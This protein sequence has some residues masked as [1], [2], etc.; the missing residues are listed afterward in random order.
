MRIFLL[1][2]ENN[3][4]NG[5]LG[6]AALR[7]CAYGDDRY[8]EGG[9]R[10]SYTEESFHWAGNVVTAER[11]RGSIR[12]RD[13]EEIERA[14]EIWIRR[15]RYRARRQAEIDVV[16]D[17]RRPCCAKIPEAQEEVLAGA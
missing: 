3:A 13:R 5:R 8:S 12:R 10:Q 17:T 1:C 6:R 4:P 7:S 9:V 14:H 15:V 2:D 11:L 16:D